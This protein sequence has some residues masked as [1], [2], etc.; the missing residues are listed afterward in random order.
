[1]GFA[2]ILR[3]ASKK[4]KRHLLMKWNYLFVEV[5]MLYVASSWKKI[6]SF[7]ILEFFKYFCKY[8][9]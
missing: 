7:F 3:D 1:M 2:A 6:L 8:F 4:I 5:F 9:N